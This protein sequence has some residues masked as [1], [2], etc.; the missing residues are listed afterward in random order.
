MPAGFVGKDIVVISNGHGFIGMSLLEE[1]LNP[2]YGCAIACVA[3][4]YTYMY[5]HI[6]HVHVQCICVYTCGLILWW[7]CV[8]KTLPMMC[9]QYMSST[10]WG[11]LSAMD[12]AAGLSPIVWHSCI[13]LNP[14][15]PKKMVV[16][17]PMVVGPDTLNSAV[18]SLCTSHMIMTGQVQPSL[19]LWLI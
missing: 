10:S 16:H 13:S 12:V 7:W 5:V 19:Y 8:F 2:P 3:F 15:S 11:I 6:I 18:S 4:M 17:G 14:L 1:D 9:L